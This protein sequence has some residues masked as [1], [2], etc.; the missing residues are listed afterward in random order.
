MSGSRRPDCGTKLA[1]LLFLEQPTH[2][3]VGRRLGQS[4]P[5]VHPGD[6]RVRHGAPGPPVEPCLGSLLS[7]G[8]CPI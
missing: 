8:A 3:N 1:A 6:A 7:V 4:M 5:V 2:E